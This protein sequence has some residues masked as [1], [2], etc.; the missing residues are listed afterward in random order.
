M[1]VRRRFNKLADKHA[2]CALMRAREL[3]GEGLLRPSFQ[4]V[5]FASGIPG[6]ADWILAVAN[7]LGRVEV[8]LS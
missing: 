1:A 7:R 5:D 2:T 8:V 6:V 3:L 4:I